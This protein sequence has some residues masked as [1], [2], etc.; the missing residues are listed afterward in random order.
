MISGAV[1]VVLLVAVEWPFASF[2]MSSAAKNR[3]F[4]TI[5]LYYALPPTSYLVRGEFYR[6]GGNAAFVKGMVIAFVFATLAIRWGISR[7][8]WMKR[9]QR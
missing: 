4:G 7:G 9:I 2:L 3:F 5:Y 6:P 1:F 8:E